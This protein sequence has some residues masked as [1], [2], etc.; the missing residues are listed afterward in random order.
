MLFFRTCAASTNLWKDVMATLASNGLY[1]A[2]VESEGHGLLEAI[3]EC[4]SRNYDI[5]YTIDDMISQ[6]ASQLVNN[7]VYTQFCDAPLDPMKVT[8]QMRFNMK[9]RMGKLLNYMYIPAI[10]S[11]LDVHV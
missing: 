8:D 4:M 5:Q 2:T 10:A 11:A 9:S 3:Q 7:P 1:V 6:V